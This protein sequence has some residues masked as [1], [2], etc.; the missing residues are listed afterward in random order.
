MIWSVARERERET[1]ERLS[2]PARKKRARARARKERVSQI[3]TGTLWSCAGEDM[4]AEG[5]ADP[6]TLRGFEV[7]SER[8]RFVVVE[9]I[10]ES[11]LLL[12]VVEGL[13]YVERIV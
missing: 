13:N 4:A 3:A 12:T 2:P 11:G 9:G 6:F 5:G 10:L 8:K 7:F 1:F